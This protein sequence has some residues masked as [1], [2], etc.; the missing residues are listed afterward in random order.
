MILSWMRFFFTL[1][2]AQGVLGVMSSEHDICV[3][4]L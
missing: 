2:D 4:V 1:E 3:V